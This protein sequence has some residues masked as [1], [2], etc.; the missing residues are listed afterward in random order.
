MARGIFAGIVWGGLVSFGALS[1]ASQIGG[2]VVLNSDA[3][4]PP[5]MAALAPDVPGSEDS[6]PAAPVPLAADV[7]LG[8]PVLPVADPSAAPVPAG[9]DTS[10]AARP[11]LVPNP[12]AP[13]APPAPGLMPDVA[14]NPLQPVLPSPEAV[15]P[16]APD[17]EG[18]PVTVGAA[19][20]APA[21]GS[22]AGAD[23]DEMAAMEAVTGAVTGAATGTGSGADASAVLQQ[24][25]APRSG[26]VTAGEGEAGHAAPGAPALSAT[27]PATIVAPQVS[28]TAEVSGRQTTQEATQKSAESTT[29][30]TTEKATSP[31]PVAPLPRIGGAGTGASGG[32]DG[33]GDAGAIAQA[34]EGLAG[35]AEGTVAATSSQQAA[36]GRTGVAITDF[37]ADFDNPLQRPLMA[38]VLLDTGEMQLSAAELAALPFPVSFSVDASRPDAAARAAQY[39]AGGYEVL[40]RVSLPAAATASD[41]AVAVEDARRQVSEAVALMDVAGGNFQL[42]HP[43]AAQIV[44][45]ASQSGL[46][47]LTYARG[48]NA[49]QQEAARTGLPAALVFREFDSAGQD[50]AA[51]KRFLDQA[52]FRAGLQSSVIMVG[53]LRPD[54][55]QALAE[56]RFGNRASRVALSP[57]SVALLAGAAGGK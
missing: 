48:L 52:A 12:Q 39:R 20:D 41:A 10:P 24:E 14:L 32:A 38:V 17:G 3:P 42:S 44:A 29:E 11:A 25:P 15:A 5:V 1:V 16:V 50:V 51:M 34:P 49:A 23:L 37:A 33:E 56:W 6:L 30:R 40:A 28:E 36:A 47:L 26:D 57:V 27:S 7:P 55:L 21:P 4:R 53:H 35:A 19:P 54:T 31:A 13:A 46:G 43:V 9:A 45:S 8:D 22:D 18:T 2:Y